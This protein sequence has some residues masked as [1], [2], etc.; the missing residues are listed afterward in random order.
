MTAR[1]IAYVKKLTQKQHN[2]RPF[3]W[4]HSID[5][6]SLNAGVWGLVTGGNRQIEWGTPWSRETKSQG[7]GKGQGKKEGIPGENVFIYK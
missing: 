2:A 6:L 3:L 4:L 7:K 1:V 5:V